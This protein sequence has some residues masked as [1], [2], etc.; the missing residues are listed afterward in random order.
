ML[1]GDKRRADLFARAGIV[2][3]VVERRLRDAVTMTMAVTLMAPDVCVPAIE[4]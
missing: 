3:R 4:A 1:V 2:K